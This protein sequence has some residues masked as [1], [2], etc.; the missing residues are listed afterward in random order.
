MAAREQSY[1][2]GT[3]GKEDLEKMMR[4]LGLHEEDLDDVVFEEEQPPAQSDN[5]WMIVVRVHI[6]RDFS[7]YWFFKN[8]RTAWDLVQLLFVVLSGARPSVLRP[9]IF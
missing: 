8:M 5:R 1:S 6:D 7:N 3:A 2:S 9:P 4:E